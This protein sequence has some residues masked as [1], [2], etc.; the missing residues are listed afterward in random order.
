MLKF[1][2]FGCLVPDNFRRKV[3]ELPVVQTKRF[4]TNYPYR[5]VTCE[6]LVAG[7]EF[8]LVDTDIPHSPGDDPKLFGKMIRLDDEPVKGDTVYYHQINP[9]ADMQCF[10][11]VKDFLDPDA[12]D[13]VPATYN[14][15]NFQPSAL[16]ALPQTSIGAFIIDPAD[17]TV[18]V[19]IT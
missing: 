11:P 8:V 13:Y 5:V 14:A 3:S 2:Q 9:A 1:M 12:N 18:S 16:T 17:N 6:D 19:N 4:H 10:S 15:V 7:A